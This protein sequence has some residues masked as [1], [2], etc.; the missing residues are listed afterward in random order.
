MGDNLAVEFGE[1]G[2]AF[3]SLKMSQ[4]PPALSQKLL[5]GGERVDLTIHQLKNRDYAHEWK[6]HT[7]SPVSMVSW[8]QKFDEV[9]CPLIGAKPKQRPAFVPDLEGV[10][11][12]HSVDG[13][14]LRDKG[15][16]WVLGDNT[17]AA[18]N[19]KI[20]NLGFTYKGGKGWWRN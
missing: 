9:I 2:N 8:E 1:A 10:L 13:Q 6:S 12:A 18:F 14:D 5:S 17:Q 4:L 16:L 20:T 15:A 3:Y 11:K 19:K 7:D